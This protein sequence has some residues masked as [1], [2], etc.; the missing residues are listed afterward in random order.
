VDD[1]GVVL[2][3]NSINTIQNTVQM[4][5]NFPVEQLQQMARKTW[6]FA[7]A[8]HTREKFAEEY[9]KTVLS[10]MGKA[11]TKNLEGVAER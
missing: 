11:E 5:S 10:I 4:V 7:R 2:K 9:K 1:F 8:N 6:E 3:D